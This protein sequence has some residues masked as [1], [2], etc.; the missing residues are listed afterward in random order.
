MNDAPRTDE[1]R[2]AE[3]IALLADQL[4]AAERRSYVDTSGGAR[5]A[6][7]VNGWAKGVGFAQ[8]TVDVLPD[9]TVQITV[10]TGQRVSEAND[11]DVRKLFRCFN[12]KFI[13]PGLVVTDQ[14]TVAFQ[15]AP[16]NLETSPY[17]A[18]TIMGMALSTIHRYAGIV[19]ALDAQ[20]DPW[21]LMTYGDDD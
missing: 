10:E 1:E 8:G 14:L 6:Y 5:T 19:L 11:G 18:D 20:T 21:R 13:V 3:T 2:M 7:A 9:A 17:A 4:E 16:F 12:E 15:T